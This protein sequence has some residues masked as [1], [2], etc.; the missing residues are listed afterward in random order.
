FS[1]NLFLASAGTDIL[2]VMGDEQPAGPGAESAPQAEAPPTVVPQAVVPQA[3]VPQ[4]VV[5]QRAALR[6]FV[7]RS[8]IARPFALRP[9]IPRPSLPRPSLPRPS[10]PR[11]AAPPDAQARRGAYTDPV[12]WAIA[13][14]VFGAYTAISVFRLMQLSQYTF[15]LGIYTEYV[16][17]YA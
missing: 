3:V 6:S 7:L 11:D 12:T 1:S 17:Q 10:L 15:D 4:A 8:G 2:R 14:A 16:K 13:A 5:P 9:L